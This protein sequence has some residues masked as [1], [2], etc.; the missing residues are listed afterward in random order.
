MGQEHP[1][2]DHEG[3]GSIGPIFGDHSFI[4]GGIVR[5]YHSSIGRKGG[6]NVDRINGAAIDV[7]GAASLGGNYGSYHQAFCI[8]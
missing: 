3:I 7:V 4:G 2:F 1:S 5:V 6:G 8:P